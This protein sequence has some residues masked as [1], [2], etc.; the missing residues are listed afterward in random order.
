MQLHAAAFLP[1][2]GARASPRGLRTTARTGLRLHDLRHGCGTLLIPL[3]VKPKLV[4]PILRH[5]R[6]A[7]TI[8]LYVHAY[9]E[10]LRNAVKTLER[11][12]DA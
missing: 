3:G 9:D 1:D 6:L 12:L 2:R 8:E 10:D 5:S 7:T 11:A 4:Q